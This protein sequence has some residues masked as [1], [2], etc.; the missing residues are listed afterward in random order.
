MRLKLISCEVMYREMCHT[1]AHSPNQVDVQFLPKG[2]HDIGARGMSERLQEM[3]DAVPNGQ[4]D[5]ILLGYALCNNGVVG[6]RSRHTPLVLPRAHDCIT[7]FLGSR[8]RYQSYFNANPGVYFETTGWL[9]RGDDKGELH[10]L[11]IQR[12]MGMDLSYEEMVAKYGED[13]AQYLFETL[14]QHTRNYSKTTFIEMGIEPDDSF[15]Q[16]A[17]GAAREKGWAFEKLPGDIG[18]IERLVNGPWNEGE[19]LVIPPGR[20]AEASFDEGVVRLEAG[21]GQP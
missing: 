20:A 13:N 10:Q 9:E 16:Q 1:V 17:A 4:Y 11:S 3:V 5:G 2:L 18:L 7:L 21:N 14:C 19:F 12:Q 6:L 15:E 8:G